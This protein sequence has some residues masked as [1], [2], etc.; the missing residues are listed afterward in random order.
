VRQL[1]ILTYDYVPDI[2]E[3]R[4]PFREEHLRLL[5]EHGCVMGGAVGDPPHGG[6]LVFESR[7]SAEAFVAS[8]PYVKNSLVAASRIDPWTLAVG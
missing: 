5:S 3:R 4:G 8:D 6:V 1:A 2:L 7:E